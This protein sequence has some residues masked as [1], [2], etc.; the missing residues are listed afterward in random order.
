MRINKYISACGIASRRAAEE[1]VKSGKITIN[2]N[3]ANIGDKINENDIVRFNNKIIQPKKSN[4]YILLNKPIGYTCTTRKFKKEKNILE[5][6]NEPANKKNKLFPVGRLDK[7]TSGL[8]I[9]TDDGEFNLKLT[10]PRYRHEKEY[11]AVVDK[12]I[13]KNL[14]QNL[15]Q[16]VKIENEGR[17]IIVAAKKARLLGDNRILL[18]ITEGKKR[19]IRKMLEA[20]GLKTLKLKR[21]GIS[22][23]ALG[24]LP[25]G[26]WRYLNDKEI[27]L[28]VDE[29]QS[30]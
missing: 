13:S 17:D 1:L 4:T 10:H 26:K 11:E 27:K 22:G 3:L 19:Q 21:T 14:I 16:G 2:D 23:L 15:L 20:I 12:K 9:L 30:N 18:I 24:N 25:I 5:L 8:L 29:N 28:L 6:I 7:N